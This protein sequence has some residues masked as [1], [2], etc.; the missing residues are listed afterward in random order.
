MEKKH[1]TKIVETKGGSCSCGGCILSYKGD[2]PFDEELNCGGGE[3]GSPS[4][5][6]KD[7]G[8]LNEE[9]CLPSPWNEK[10]YPEI[11][12]NPNG[13]YVISAES[14]DCLYFIFGYPKEK[15]IANWN[16]RT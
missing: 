15:A 9:G 1:L 8:I 6:Y 5:V 10:L 4:Y 14:L 3:D 16:K 13:N 7:L 12:E 11:R 2:C